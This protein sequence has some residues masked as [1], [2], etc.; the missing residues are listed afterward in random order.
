MSTAAGLITVEE[1]RKLDDPPGAYLELHHG[2]MVQVTR[3]RLKHIRL[4][5]IL[6]QVLEGVTKS[7]G[8]VVVELPFRTHPEHDLRVADVA[9]VSWDRWNSLDEDLFGAPELV[10]EV[11]SPSNSARELKEKAQLCFASGCLEFW[12]V[13]PDLGLVE[14]ST[15][16]GKS[17]Q[18]RQ[19][20]MIQSNFATFPAADIF[21]K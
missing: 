19:G 14:V 5:R 15:P 6:Q 4:Q 12:T 8:E 18:Y 10:I 2:E 7:F 9:L 13:Y 17:V 20:D 11:E 21:G 16:D 1:L 3:P